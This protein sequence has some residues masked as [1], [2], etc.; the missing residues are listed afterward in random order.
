M[1]T[2]TVTV[3]TTSNPSSSPS[4]SPRSGSPQGP[5]LGPIIGGV[6]AAVAILLLLLLL[7]LLASRRQREIRLRRAASA[8]IDPTVTPFT[9]KFNLIDTREGLGSHLNVND[10]RS[11]TPGPTGVLCFNLYRHPHDSSFYL[12]HVSQIIPPT[13]VGLKRARTNYTVHSPNH[14]LITNGAI[15]GEMTRTLIY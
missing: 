15:T 1:P 11:E 4:P 14:D 3:T 5:Q 9:G 6:V 2:T 7:K 10:E 8:E 13:N 12:V